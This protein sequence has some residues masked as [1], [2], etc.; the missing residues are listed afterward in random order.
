ML[1]TVDNRTTRTVTYV[2]QNIKAS[3]SH[4]FSSTVILDKIIQVLR[5]T[6]IPLNQSFSQ[7]L[8]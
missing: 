7:I 2:A 3:V 8:M 5:K 6:A 4:T 1:V